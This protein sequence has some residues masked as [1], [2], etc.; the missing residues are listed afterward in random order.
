M[1]RVLQSR[2]SLLRGL[3]C[4]LHHHCSCR[5]RNWSPSHN[6]RCSFLHPSSKSVTWSLH[7][8]P[9]TTALEQGYNT[10]WDRNTPPT[11]AAPAVT[12]FAAA[13]PPLFLFTTKSSQ[14]FAIVC[15][16]TLL[17]GRELLNSSSSSPGSKSNSSSSDENS[18][19]AIVCKA[20]TETAELGGG[21]LKCLDG[22]S[23]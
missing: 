18:S 2:H 6:N 8:Q 19:G 14:V 5:H 7:Q 4:F 11:S 9:S 1:H 17:F 10:T 3:T 20:G 12:F 22:W 16:G 15:C 21:Q 23:Q 13:R